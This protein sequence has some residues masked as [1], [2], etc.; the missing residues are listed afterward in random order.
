MR[1]D[2]NPFECC[3]LSSHCDAI[4]E[5]INNFFCIFNPKRNAK[6]KF[7]QNCELT[8][9]CC[10]L[11]FLIKSGTLNAVTASIT[12][13]SSRPSRQSADKSTT[14]RFDLALRSR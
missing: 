12:S 11:G 2:T 3:F 5:S 9:C 4:I 1:R 8:I 13:A 14:L 10:V 7:D 6:R